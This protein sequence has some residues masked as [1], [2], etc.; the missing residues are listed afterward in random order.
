MKAPVKIILLSAAMLLVIVGC[1]KNDPPAYQIEAEAKT[2]LN[3]AYGNDAKQ[4]MDVYLP[5]NRTSNTGIIILVHGGSFIGGDKNDLTT[6]ARYLAI[7]GYAVINVNYRLVDGTGLLTQ[8]P[9]RIESTVKIKDQVTDIS[10]IVDYAIANA[11]DWVVNSDRIVLIGHSAGA[12]LA[13]LYS[14]DLRNDSKVKAVSNLAGAL[15]LVFTN[16]PNWQFF[17]PALF[18]AGYRYTGFELAVANE[19]QYK[20]ISALNVANADRKIPTLN[21]LPSN[22]DIQG[23]PKQDITTYSAFTAKL[24]ELK[25]PNHFLY[26]S[27]ADHN[28]SQDGKWQEVLEASLLFFNTA[29]D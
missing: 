19:Q 12:S 24:N 8:N 1:K 22:N 23:L 4:K 18:E 10:S 21:V 14:Y 15:D 26:V 27:G 29:L 7:S 17:P 5:A 11:K 9:S 28:F 2:M 3:V 25:V 6:Q 13:L 16:I 20:D